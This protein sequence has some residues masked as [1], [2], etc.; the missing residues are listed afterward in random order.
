MSWIFLRH[1]VHVHKLICCLFC[2][3]FV[4]IILFVDVFKFA[5]KAWLLRDTVHSTYV[6]DGV[7]VVSYGILVDSRL[8]EVADD[9]V[10]WT[11][12]HV[13]LVGCYDSV[14]V[15]VVKIERPL[16]FLQ[17]RSSQQQ[18]QPH[19]EL[20]TTIDNNVYVQ[21]HAEQERSD[22]LVNLQHSC[23]EGTL[24]A[25]QVPSLTVNT[26]RFPDTSR[27][28]RL[29]SAFE[30]FLLRD[31][32]LARNMLCVCLSVRPSVTSRSS[33]E[34]LNIGSHNRLRRQGLGSPTVLSVLSL[35][36]ATFD[37]FSRPVHIAASELNWNSGTCVAVHVVDINWT[38]YFSLLP[39]CEHAFREHLSITGTGFCGS[40][41]LIATQP[42]LN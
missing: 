4:N 9:V 14:S 39:R 20:L 16:E 29:R 40:D 3:I 21:T 2:P 27:P 37:R 30:A 25:L 34:W 22:S 33:T 42:K 23:L 6:E 32:T 1:P 12:D 28:T 5:F 24:T 8:S 11:H 31:A 7:D 13:H 26:L 41:A 19:H 18:R 15:D 10:H 35:T 17:Q 36:V 38:E